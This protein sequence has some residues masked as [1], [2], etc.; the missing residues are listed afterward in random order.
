MTDLT[1]ADWERII[2]PLIMDT[3]TKETR[4]ASKSINGATHWWGE[5]SGS[6]DC[7]RAAPFT[8][9]INNPRGE[10]RYIIVDI[11]AR[12]QADNVEAIIQYV[13][14]FYPQEASQ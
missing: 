3:N 1:Q 11:A 13:N 2:H 10:A 7:N 4:W 5:G 6:C 9:T 14:Q 12:D 8:G